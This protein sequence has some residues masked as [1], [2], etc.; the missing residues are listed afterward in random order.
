MDFS[1]DSAVAEQRSHNPL[2]AGSIPAPATNFYGPS[3]AKQRECLAF[4]HRH[5][6]RGR[7]PT[8]GGIARCL[9]L[10]SRAAALYVVRGLERRRL[11]YRAPA[12]QG[13]RRNYIL[14]DAAIIEL[15]CGKSAQ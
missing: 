4:L 15:A 5:I 9:G 6:S 7:R 3:L 10:N 11:I 14:T 2:V 8:L 1:R 12:S 13:R